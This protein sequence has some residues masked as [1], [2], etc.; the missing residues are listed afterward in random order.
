MS[1]PTDPLRV[2]VLGADPVLRR[3]VVQFLNSIM[4]SAKV[5]EA[6]NIAEILDRGPASAWSLI[7]LDFEGTRDFALLARLKLVLPT[8]PVLVLDIHPSQADT[9]QVMA[10]G[11]AGCL[12][13]AGPVGDWRIALETVARGTSDPA[14]H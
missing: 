10:A 9:E 8:V 12:N 5:S 4:L 7:V 14:R 2:L 13:K 1:Q 11:A 3:G 6:S